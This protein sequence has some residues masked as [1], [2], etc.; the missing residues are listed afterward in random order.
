[1]KVNQKKEKSGLLIKVGHKFCFIYH[2]TLL[3]QGEK[4]QYVMKKSLASMTK[5]KVIRNS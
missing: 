4:Q 3:F 1:M 5:N 2:Q